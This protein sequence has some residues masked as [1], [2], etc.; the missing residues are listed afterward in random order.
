[1]DKISDKRALVPNTNLTAE[2][3]HAMQNMLNE[4]KAPYG[5]TVCV[6]ST[7]KEYED[8]CKELYKSLPFNPFIKWA[9]NEVSDKE[10][11]EQVQD[12]QV[13]IYKHQVKEF[14]F[15]KCRNRLLEEVNTKWVLFLDAD[16]RLLFNDRQLTDATKSEAGFFMV[17]V[18]GYDHEGKRYLTRLPRL[19][20]SDIRY[21]RKVHE[22]IIWDAKKKGYDKGISNITI[23][24]LGYSDT[25]TT[26]KKLVRNNE[27]L[28]KDLIGDDLKN[29]DRKARLSFYHLYR[30]LESLKNNGFFNGVHDTN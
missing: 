5:L 4:I 15:S 25:A 7:L 1:M 14:D 10:T 23:E 30:H 21:E 26:L 22:Q 8:N 13:S 27:L 17:S 24:H 3:K 19:F 9:I 29:P 20:R 28:I 6:I 18:V 16:E 11:F 12:G 2:N